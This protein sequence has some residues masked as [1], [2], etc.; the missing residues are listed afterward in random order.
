MESRMQSS[1]SIQSRRLGIFLADGF[2]L[3]TLTSLITPLDLANKILG[4]PAYEWRFVGESDDDVVSDC[5]VGVTPHTRAD[6]EKRRS[7]EARAELVAIISSPTVDWSCSEQAISWIR[8]SL[9]EGADIVGIGGGALALAE[10]G[11]LKDRKCAT[12]WDLYP[13]SIERFPDVKI[14]PSYFEI[15]GPFHTC[16]G[17]AA[18]FDL[19]LHL[20][21]R[22]FGAPLAER[23]GQKALH[24]TPRIMGDRQVSGL[25]TKLDMIGSPLLKI[26]KLM[27]QNVAEPLPIKELTSFSRYS[28]RQ[29]ERL[30]EQYLGESPKRYYLKIRVERAQSLL[31]HSALSVLEVGIATGFLSASHFSKVYKAIVGCT[32]QQTRA[33]ARFEHGIQTWPGFLIN[34][35]SSNDNR[36]R[37]QGRTSL[38]APGAR[39]A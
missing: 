29:I 26:L 30:F 13:A 17:G 39:P 33:T 18:A 9:A 16:A 23:I 34:E 25:H 19:S 12:H 35:A 11:L 24:G 15:D 14:L 1:G 4:Y 10:H 2:S 8:K 21:K 28:R 3:Q 32:P 5:G 27:E 7:L 6:I 20:V 36:K 22:D 31:R 37:G 38:S